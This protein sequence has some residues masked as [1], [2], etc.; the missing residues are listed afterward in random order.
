L[1]ILLIKAAPN[2]YF[3]QFFYKMSQ[4]KEQSAKKNNTQNDDN[5]NKVSSAGIPYGAGIPDFN[6]M[7][8]NDPVRFS[9]G[10]SDLD[11][12]AAAPGVV[13]IGNGSVR[14]TGGGMYV[15]PDHP[16]F[17]EPPNPFFGSVGPE[18]FPPGAVP[19]G[20]RFDPVMPFGPGSQ[21]LRPQGRIQPQ[22][23]HSRNLPFSGDPDFDELKPPGFNDE[24]M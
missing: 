17:N 13:G 18:R 16:M 4:R 2:D 19:P 23:P 22:F 1:F 21:P 7:E 10:R 20:A 6:L 12:F 5:V 9:V 3:C 15:G 8:R 11:P 24:F 14:S